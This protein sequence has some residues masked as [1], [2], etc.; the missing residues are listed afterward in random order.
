MV[1]QEIKTRV[2]S[3]ER[4][5]ML[6]RLRPCSSKRKRTE[7]IEQLLNYGTKFHASCQTILQMQIF[8]DD[9]QPTIMSF[10]LMHMHNAVLHVFTLALL[11]NRNSQEL[12]SLPLTGLIKLQHKICVFLFMHVQRC[13]LPS[14]VLRW[15]WSYSHWLHPPH[16]FPAVPMMPRARK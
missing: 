8:S 3:D 12:P 5:C 11:I 16:R 15:G 4:H 13:S 14:S 9:F 10:I 6:F 7:L 2:L 1:S